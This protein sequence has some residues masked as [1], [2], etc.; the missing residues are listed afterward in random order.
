MSLSPVYRALQ[1]LQTLHTGGS[2]LRLG[3]LLLSRRG[4]QSARRGLHS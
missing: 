3:P 4:P 2:A 1:A